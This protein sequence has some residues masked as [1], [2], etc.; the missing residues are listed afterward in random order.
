MPVQLI[1][2]R[3]LGEFVHSFWHGMV[4]L[5]WSITIAITLSHN[6]IILS[7]HI[8]LELLL[9]RNCNKLQVMQL[10]LNPALTEHSTVFY[11]SSP[12]SVILPPPAK[13]LFT[14]PH[15]YN[16]KSPHVY[17]SSSTA[18]LI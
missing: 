15:V 16:Y 8:S 5:Q 9:Y 11:F 4:K 6:Y 18:K 2:D 14:P 7:S 1:L 3:I 10:Q 13:G 17:K 12:P